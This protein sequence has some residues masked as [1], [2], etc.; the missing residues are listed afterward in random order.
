[1]ISRN[2]GK[3]LELDCKSAELKLLDDLRK[4]AIAKLWISNG[5]LGWN[6][7]KMMRQHKR[8]C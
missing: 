5:T 8:K 7:N 2:I 3:M 4:V 1:M 6:K